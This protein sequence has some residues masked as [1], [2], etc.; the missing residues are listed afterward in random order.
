MPS[1]SHKMTFNRLHLG[2]ISVYE[3]KME[4]TCHRENC[5]IFRLLKKVNLR[6]NELVWYSHYFIE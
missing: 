6:V 3:V 1:F 4:S 5:S 2:K